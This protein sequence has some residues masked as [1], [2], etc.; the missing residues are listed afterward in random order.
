MRVIYSGLFD[1]Y[2]GL[3]V[4]LGHLGEGLPFWLPRLDLGWLEPAISEEKR[5]RCAKRPSE[6]IKTN[7]IVTTS[8]MFF[9]PAF[10]CT[11]L[12]LGADNIAFAVDHPYADN[13][14]ASQFIE[15]IPICDPDREKISHLNAERL[16]KLT[17]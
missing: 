3:K 6:Y 8:G 9:Q 12:A 15:E 5:P 11:Y 13:K 16:F 14:A 2:P 7:F 4:I 1:H 17:Y 10:L